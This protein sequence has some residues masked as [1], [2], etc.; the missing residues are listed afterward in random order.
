[1]ETCGAYAHEVPDPGPRSGLSS[2]SAGAGAD[3]GVHIKDEA[4]LDRGPEE[5]QAGVWLEMYG[6][7]Y[8]WKLGGYEFEHADEG[9]DEHYDDEYEHEE[10]SDPA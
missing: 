10:F 8:D 2:G 7:Q 3:P 5:D 1:M 4:P 6:Y 9:L